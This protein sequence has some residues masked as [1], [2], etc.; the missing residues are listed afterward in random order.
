MKGPTDFIFKTEPYPYQLESF[1][2]CIQRINVGLLHEMGLGKTKISIDVARYYLEMNNISKVLIVCPPTLLYNWQK[3]IKKHSDYDSLI[4]TSQRKERLARFVNTDKIFNIINYEALF[5]T[6]RD[7]GV[8][9]KEEGAK[10]RKIYVAKNSSELLK[11]LNYDLIIFDE[12]AK[13]IK[14]PGTDRTTASILLSDVAKYKLILTGTPIANKPIDIWAQFRVLDGGKTFS[15]N[16]FKFRNYFFYSEQGYGYEIWKPKT[17]KFPIIT[18]GIYSICIRKKKKDVLP[19]LPEKIFNSIYIS[20]SGSFLNE[21]N[22]LSKKILSEIETE[23]GSTEITIT[24]ILQKLIRLQQLTSG[25][26]VKDNKNVKLINTPKLDATLEQIELVIDSE[27]SIVVWCRF[28]KSI[29]II[30][31]ALN[32]RKIKYVTMSGKDKDKKERYNKWKS[33]QED[34]T[35]VFIGQVESGG[36]GIELF[37]KEASETKN[38]HMLFYENTWDLQTREQAMDRIH[39]IGQ[40]SVCVYTDITI[41]GTIDEKIL[42]TLK[43]NKSIAD[44]I[45]EKGV[46]E[47]LK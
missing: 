25:F 11:E 8:L 21:Y 35:P 14:S 16:F 31:S 13:Y 37:K 46:K 24:S 34:D 33:F 27:E 1:L 29:E 38:Q 9:I 36:F 20:M 6:L 12:S 2:F 43:H 17:E 47:W 18:K 41:K 7:L 3:E 39:R 40:K 26:M 10:K 19:E 23:E 32:R 15:K 4:I 5:P 28:I 45:L 44:E 22:N 42:H 30:A